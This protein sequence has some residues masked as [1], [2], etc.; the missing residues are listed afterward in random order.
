[1]AS[2]DLERIRNAILDHRY[3]LTEHAY[4]ELDEDGLDVL[5]VESVILTGQ[6]DQVLAQDARGVRFVLIGK[7]ADQHATV[8]VVVR[9]VEHDLLLIITAYEIK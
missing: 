2:R 6:V 8:G 9:F 5:D 1:M 4:D 7:A 3:V